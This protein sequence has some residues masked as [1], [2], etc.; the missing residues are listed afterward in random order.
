MGKAGS[1]LKTAITKFA[2]RSIPGMLS[3]RLRKSVL[4]SSSKRTPTTGNNSRT[5]AT[6]TKGPAAAIK[7]SCHGFSGRL[8]KLATPPIGN[9]V[10]SRVLQPNRRAV[11]TCP[12]SCINTQPNMRTVKSTISSAA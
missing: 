6:F 7:S 3:A 12:N 11:R 9:R 5:I 10:T 1:R 4:E 8:S 2:A